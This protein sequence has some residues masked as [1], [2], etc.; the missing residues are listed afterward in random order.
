M[1]EDA[2]ASSAEPS[3]RLRNI[4][5]MRPFNQ[6]AVI[7]THAIFYFSIGA[8]ALT[9]SNLLVFTRFSREAF[10]FMSA[11]A[12]TY[13]YGDA[14]RISLGH[15]WRRRLL[16]IALPYITW[17]A[18]YFIYTS[19]SLTKSFP[20]YSVTSASFLS[21]A[22]LK[23][24][25][26]FTFEGYYHLYYLVVLFEF[27]LLFP[28]VFSWLRRWR[29]RHIPIIVGALALQSLLPI[30]ATMHY[31][32]GVDIEFWQTRFVF[33]YVFYLVGGVIVALHFDDVHDWICAHGS[34]ILAATVISALGALT[35]NDL[36]ISGRLGQIIRPDGSPFSIAVL[37]YNICATLSVYLLGVWLVSPRRSWRTRAIVQSGSDNSYGI[38]L[39]Q[40][41]WIPAL[42]RL[43]A[44]TG[45]HLPWL[46][47]LIVA[48]VITFALG[49]IFSSLAARTPL[50]RALSGRAQT[51][52]RSLIPQGRYGAITPRRDTENGPPRIKL[53][54]E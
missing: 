27:Y 29:Q 6:A 24:L 4:D 34:M 39:S 5:A 46:A 44:F 3:V 48:A 12:I 53:E 1:S 47:A 17:T 2:S 8:S 23:R 32:P 35:L 36:S 22:A 41:I 20:F 26:D 15:F 21:L 37:P 16:F 51:T 54:L 31:L 11:F 28:L 25:R 9:D 14:E 33:F 40:M 50:A 45:V 52:W 38:Y 30:A 19:L 42:L 13:S 10:L 49:W 7:S 43:R 18:I